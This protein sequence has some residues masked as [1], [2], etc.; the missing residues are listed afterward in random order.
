MTE[1][2]RQAIMK[3]MAGR[4]VAYFNAV[5]DNNSFKIQIQLHQLSSF[6]E[7]V[8]NALA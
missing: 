5:R 7:M 4:N 1:Q 3:V 6:T 8:G 2:D